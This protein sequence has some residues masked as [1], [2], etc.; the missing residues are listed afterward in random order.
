MF[1]T[2]SHFIGDPARRA[3]KLNSQV[4]VIGDGAWIG[5][6]SV[7]LPG[8]SIGRGSVIAAGAVVNQ[9][10]DSDWLYAGIPAIKKKY[11]N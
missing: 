2:A 10:C 6:R 4:I 3:G 1:C 9:N 5:A 8:V 7:I 11:L